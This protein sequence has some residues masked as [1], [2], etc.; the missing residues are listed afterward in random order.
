MS[1]RANTSRTDLFTVDE[2]WLRAV[3]TKWFWLGGILGFALGA[4]AMFLV[5]HFRWDLP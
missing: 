2:K 5:C 3:F 1:E 4:L